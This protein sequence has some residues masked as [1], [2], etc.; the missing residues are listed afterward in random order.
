MT[1]IETQATS[2]DRREREP[3]WLDIFFALLT[4]AYAV[5]FVRQPSPFFADDSFFYLQVG[6]N[7]ALGYGSTFNR[8]MQTNGYHPIWMLLCAAVYRLFPDRITG[9][10]MIAALIVLLNIVV[11]VVAGRLLRR[12]RAPAWVA[13][14]IL[15]PFLFGLQLGTESSLSAAMLAGTLLALYKFFEHP[16]WKSGFAFNVLAAFSVLSRLDS[17]FVIACVWIAVL[18]WCLQQPQQAEGKR[19]LRIHLAWIPL[20]AVLWGAYLGSNL[21][22]FHIL[23][24]ISGLLKSSNGGDHAL[25]HNLPHTA[26]IS[27]VICAISIAIL[28]RKQRDRWFLFA[29]LPFFIGIVM[30]AAYITLRMTGE[31]RWTWYYVSWALLAAL[32]AS[33]ATACLFCAAPAAVRGSLRRPSVAATLHSVG[34][35]LAIV[36]STLLWYKMGW[37][38]SRVQVAEETTIPALRQVLD[39]DHMSRLLAYDQPGGM[40]YFTDAAVVPLDGLMADREFQ[41]ELAQNGIGD[42]IRKDN[43]D[44]FAGPTVPFDQWGKDT[45]CG[46]LFLESTKYTCEPWMAGPNGQPQWMITGVEVYSRLPLAPAGYISLPPSHIVWTGKNYL[47]IWRISPADSQ[48]KAQ[49]SVVAAPQGDPGAASSQVQ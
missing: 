29:E 47:T 20:Y 3:L 39:D 37:K 42:F 14:T 45:Y 8:L 7:F 22:W 35:L 34:I 30:H 6:R 31:T 5:L 17:I 11:L 41:T 26:L 2:A 21:F 23:M 43:I 16:D 12:L 24:P 46:H 19:A 25:G 38:H 9:L 10:H 13:W 32:T 27:L 18:L 44:G 40:A 15:I 28:W 49:D 1:E 33:R 36:F 4:M 48:P